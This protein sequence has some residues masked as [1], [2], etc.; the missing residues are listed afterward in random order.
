MQLRASARPVI[1]TSIDLASS[2][3]PPAGLLGLTIFGFTE[4]GNGIDLAFL[5]MPTC[6]LYSSL[7][8]LASFLPAIGSGSTPLSIPNV[9]GLA[10]TIVSSQSAVMVPG[11]NPFGFVSSNGVRLTLNV[12]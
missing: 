5:G 8:V 10:G 4:Y 3:I 11:I 9:P 1:G 6:S 7:D 12:N 2:S